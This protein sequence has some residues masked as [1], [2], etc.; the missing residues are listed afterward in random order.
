MT[1]QVGNFRAMKKGIALPKRPGVLAIAI[2]V[3]FNVWSLQGQTGLYNTPYLTIGP[4]YADFGLIVTRTGPGVIVLDEQYNVVL[5]IMDSMANNSQG[6]PSYGGFEAK[7]GLCL[8]PDTSIYFDES[9]RDG[10]SP[11]ISRYSFAGDSLWSIAPYV[12]SSKENAVTTILSLGGGRYAACGNIASDPLYGDK[13]F[14]LVF[15]ESGS[16]LWQTFM[17]SVVVDS[18]M[19]IEDAPFRASN[20]VMTRDGDLVVVADWAD[21]P[22]VL[23]K[24]DTSGNLIWE[25]YTNVWSTTGSLSGRVYRGL[26]LADNGSFWVQCNAELSSND[27]LGRYLTDTDLFPIGIAGLN[28]SS[29]GG[30]IQ[31]SDGNFVSGQDNVVF[32]F[33]SGGN[34]LWQ[35]DLSLLPF[36]D[37]ATTMRVTSQG[38]IEVYFSVTFNLAQN[39]PP[40]GLAIAVLD[41]DGWLYKDFIIGNIYLD[42]NGDCQKQANEPGLKDWVL[43]AD[44]NS[45][46]R[47]ISHTDGSYTINV[48]DDS[49]SI[50]PVPPLPYLS[51][52]GPSCA[53]IPV[54]TSFGG[55]V[56]ADT[57][58]LDMPVVPLISCPLLNVEIA[59]PGLSR[60]Y[61]ALYYVDY[62]NYG[63][64]GVDSVYVDIDF[65]P[66]L[67]VLSSTIPGTLISGN[68][69][70]YQLDSLVISECGT[71]MVTVHVDCDSTVLGQTHC[72][73]AHIY[74]DTVCLPANVLSSWDGS[75]L[76]VSG[77]CDNEDTVRLNVTNEGTGAMSSAEPIIIIEDNVMLVNSTLQLNPQENYGRNYVANGATYTLRARNTPGQP[78]AFEKI[79]SVEGCGVD[80]SGGISL[81]IVEEFPQDQPEPFLARDCQANTG[82]FDPNDKTPFPMG[83]G[84]PGYIENGQRMKYRIRFQN[85][86]TDTA[87]LVVILDTLSSYLDVS[88]FSPLVASHSYT[89]DIL[90]TNILQFTFENILLPDSN[91][92]EPGSHGF[93]QFGISPFS[94][95][96]EGTVINN[97]AAIYFDFN[98]PVITNM[99]VNTITTDLKTK[100]IVGITDL[101]VQDNK[102]NIYPNP[103]QNTLQF[104][105]EQP[106]QEPVSFRVYDLLGNLINTYE[107][108]PGKNMV[109]TDLQLP[110]GT[111]IYQ[112]FVGQTHYANG[113]II[114][115]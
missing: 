7:H 48:P 112:L 29:W 74:P 60:C 39:F 33:D 85:T 63:T 24:F 2:L 109:L 113:K 70:R 25:T 30:P 28:G 43:T 20:M 8:G 40:S 110:A 111:Y 61:D 96:A 64:L 80:S 46:Y 59:S 51:I 101:F 92:N 97:E 108:P 81:G 18:A 73:E 89:V 78:F 77:S 79:V 86:G 10:G 82:S 100:F 76:K 45:S 66:Y 72:T 53:P 107:M 37:F 56:G 114:A 23:Y 13:G 26:E 49:F 50:Y 16:I 99:T 84:A 75:S 14:L 105:F 3:C 38:Y 69:Y 58:F 35:R 9:L 15:N 83:V 41:Q 36:F 22:Y 44:G 6:Y 27:S 68:T 32:K 52:T 103:T 90:D 1:D 62:C 102:L 4:P 98:L 34:I 19:Q 67:T 65:D 88:T 5:T 11:V 106:V 115:Y 94:N 55:N 12:D 47:A 57:F 95:L 31:T 93:I 71:F 42:Y 104:S 91:V 54:D 17:D 21:G 87:F